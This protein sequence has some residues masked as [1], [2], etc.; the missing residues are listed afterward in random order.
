MPNYSPGFDKAN[1]PMVRMYPNVKGREPEYMLNKL[2]EVGCK[3]RVHYQLANQTNP[4]ADPTITDLCTINAIAACKKKIELKSDF[5]QAIAEEIETV[6]RDCRKAGYAVDAP[7]VIS[8]MYA[9]AVALASGNYSSQ[10]S[11]TQANYGMF[12]SSKGSNSKIL[13]H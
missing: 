10:M 5:S 4:F 2:Q 8:A 9:V 7:E 6:V 13:K 3:F 1:N 11:I 12:D